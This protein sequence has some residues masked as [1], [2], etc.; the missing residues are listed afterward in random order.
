MWAVEPVDNLV[1][2][3]V[4]VWGEVVGGLVEPGN[5]CLGEFPGISYDIR[6]EEVVAGSRRALLT[7]S[8]I[9]YPRVRSP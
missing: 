1:D 7:A 4:E 6:V 2:I 5:G 8:E 3:C 9:K